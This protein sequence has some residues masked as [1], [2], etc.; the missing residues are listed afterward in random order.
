[1]HLTK[2]KKQHATNQNSAHQNTAAK[3]LL[4]IEKEEK[5]MQTTSGEYLLYITL[6]MHVF[7]IVRITI[8]IIL[9]RFSREK[10][11]ER[12]RE[13]EREKIERENAMM[14]AR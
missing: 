14:T 5:K 4:E 10:E 8:H 9:M 7:G 11:R 6:W 12:E 3:L 1:M 13:R 2:S